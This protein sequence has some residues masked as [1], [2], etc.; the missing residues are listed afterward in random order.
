MCVWCVCFNIGVYLYVLG[1]VVCFVDKLVFYFG[2][3]EDIKLV[4]GI[5]RLVWVD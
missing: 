4:K 2:F 3:V 5:V 1:V